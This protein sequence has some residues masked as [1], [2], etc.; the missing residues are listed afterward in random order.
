MEDFSKESA[1][2][3]ISNGKSIKNGR[4]V[5][6][7]IWKKHILDEIFLLSTKSFNYARREKPINNN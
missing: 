4:F 1:F 6:S 3:E 2:L 5:D 7:I